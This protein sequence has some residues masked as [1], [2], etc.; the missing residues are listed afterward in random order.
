MTIKARSLH[1]LNSQAAWDVVHRYGEVV[2]EHMSIRA[3][4]YCY[5]YSPSL[6]PVGY[7]HYLQSCGQHIDLIYSDNEDFADHLRSYY[8]IPKPNVAVLHHPILASD[9]DEFY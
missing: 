4:L 6:R 7:P 5:D 9:R 1:I 3:S 2:R 8:G